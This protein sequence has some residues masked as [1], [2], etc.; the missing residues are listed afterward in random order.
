M[1]YKQNDIDI[2]L[3]DKFQGSEGV[4]LNRALTT[5]IVE[6]EAQLKEFKTQ[7]TFCEE[8]I[9]VLKKKIQGED[10][11]IKI[12]YYNEMIQIFSDHKVIVNIGSWLT[13]LSADIKSAQ[14]NLYFDKTEWGKRNAVKQL[15]TTLYEACSDIFE[16]LGKDFKEITTSRIDISHI[17]DELIEI[18]KRL[19]QYKAGNRNYFCEVRNNVSAHKDKN[20]LIQIQIIEDIDWGSFI[21]KT[22]EFENIIN[23]LG[24]C[25]KKVLDLNFENLANSPKGKGLI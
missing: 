17:N 23:D 11:L 10:I 25:I 13:I 6:L 24:A 1:E 16:L 21:E 9:L 5:Q 19:V 4:A 3:K 14:K 20:S 15:C 2:Y 7:L 8:Q 18:R 22:S 12:G